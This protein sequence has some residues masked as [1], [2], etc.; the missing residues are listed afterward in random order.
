V[1]KMGPPNTLDPLGQCIVPFGFFF[2]FFLKKI[3]S[4]SFEIGRSWSL[5][6]KGQN[7]P[8]NRNDNIAHC[9]IRDQLLS[10]S[11]EMERIHFPK[12]GRSCIK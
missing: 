8:K 11:N 5:L 3:L 9:F 7:C 1:K 12:K 6:N 4:I 10:I 2:F